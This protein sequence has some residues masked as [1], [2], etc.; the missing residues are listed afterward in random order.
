ME[1]SK[2]NKAEL[3]EALSALQAKAEEGIHSID[4]ETVRVVVEIPHKFEVKK[5][6]ETF[7]IRAEEI[8]PAGYRHLL[9]FGFKQAVTD[10][11]NS[12]G[13]NGNTEDKTAAAHTKMRNIAEGNVGGGGRE[14]D[15]FLIAVKA[16]VLQI[17][18]QVKNKETQAKHTAKE[19]GAKMRD[20]GGPVA[21]MRKVCGLLGNDADKVLA[22][23]KARVENTTSVD[24]DLDI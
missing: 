22:E 5:G 16:D 12:P 3:I 20:L 1:L 21:A 13:K 14:S 11:Y 24:I 10:A 15:P 9:A 23:I 8:K 7:F 4:N 6:E 19:A 18:R 2:M 17:L